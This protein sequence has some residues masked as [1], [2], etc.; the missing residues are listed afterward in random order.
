MKTKLKNNQLTIGSW[1]TIG[2]GEIAEIYAN[3]SLD[4]ICI[5]LE[6]SPL[7]LAECSSLINIIGSKNKAPLVR[8]SW[9][10]HVQIKR[11]MDLG[12]HGIIVPQIESP[13]D[14][15]NAYKA[16]HYPP[17]G[18]RGVGLSRAQGYGTSFEEY[19]DWM[20][21]H[22]ILVPQ[23]E[24]KMAIENIESII[25]MPEVDAVILGP[26]DLSASL[27]DPGNFDSI[28]FKDAIIKVETACKKVNK[29]I[30]IHIVEPDPKQL[31]SKVDQGY[32]FIAYSVDFRILDVGMRS[33]IKNVINK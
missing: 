9:N 26:Y 29:P 30:G 32:T 6:H 1:I 5:D 10:D 14:C 28:A 17:T 22:S 20:K 33:G 3:T 11:V 24:N 19:K 4:W 12:A 2:S 31:Q 23:I 25:N 8:L 16:M 21:Q 27:G 18:I 7:D 15:I 13:E